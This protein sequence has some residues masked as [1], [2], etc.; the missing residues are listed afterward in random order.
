[1]SKGMEERSSESYLQEAKEIWHKISGNLPVS[2]IE[3]ERSA[4]E[5][6]LGVFQMGSF[7]YNIFNVSKGQIE[8]TSDGVSEL[9]GL[10]PKELTIDKFFEC[11][12]P[13]DVGTVVMFERKMADFLSVLPS[14]K[15]LNYRSR[16]DY[17]IKHQNGDYIRIMQQAMPLQSDKDGAV[18]RSLAVFTD[19][20]H[21]KKYGASS[22]SIIGSNGDP[23]YHDVEST[24]SFKMQR[25]ILTS[26]EREILFLLT[27]GKQTNE[28]ASILNISI[29][30]V[31][32]HRK[33]I[34]Q[35]TDCRSSIEV[36]SK[37]FQLGWI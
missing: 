27:R 34:L 10:E 32:N 17:R 21:L 23:S 37:A 14:E 4:Y 13:E 8:F 12:H 3:V 35:K 22:L 5:E 15:I 33:S 26:R 20:S 16:Y 30:T 7:F 29:S 11:I 6:M 31:T 25:P 2:D 28:I 36:V 24:T 1:M 19:I 9:M 18:M